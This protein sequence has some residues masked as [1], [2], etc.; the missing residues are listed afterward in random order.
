MSVLKTERVPVMF[1]TDRLRKVD[2]YSFE[3]RIR[4][5]AEAIR[6]LIDKGLNA[7]QSETK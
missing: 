5:R 1:D 2:D 7:S 6:Q 3:N 4:T